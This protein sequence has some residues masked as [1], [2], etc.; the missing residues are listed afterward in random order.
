M[1]WSIRFTPYLVFHSCGPSSHFFNQKKEGKHYLPESTIYILLSLH[2]TFPNPPPPQATQKKHVPSIKTPH[3][4]H[5]PSSPAHG[6]SFVLQHR[7]SAK[8]PV[9]IHSAILR[10]HFFA[11]AWS[12]KRVFWVPPLGPPPKKEKK[13]GNIWLR[14]FLKSTSFFVELCHSAGVLNITFP[15]SV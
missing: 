6:W 13:R 1:V 15:S 5:P 4:L 7:S 3:I 10:I 9:P 14:R 2:L 8:V 12:Q 11:Q